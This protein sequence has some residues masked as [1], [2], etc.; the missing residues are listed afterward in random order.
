MGKKICIIFILLLAMPFTASYC[1]AEEGQKAIAGNSEKP[2]GP[3]ARPAA[4]IVTKEAAIGSVIEIKN[5]VS[6]NAVPKTID[7][8]VDIVVPVIGPAVYKETNYIPAKCD[9]DGNGIVDQ[10]DLQIVRGLQFAVKGSPRYD[11]RAD[12]NDSGNISAADLT[13]V[14]KNLGY[15][16]PQNPEGAQSDVADQAL[17]KGGVVPGY[18]DETGEWHPPVVGDIGEEIKEPVGK[19]GAVMT[20]KVTA[21]KTAVKKPENKM[22]KNVSREAMIKA[23]DEAGTTPKIL[24]KK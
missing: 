11:A 20:S 12:I 24:K 3:S 15:I 2:V 22:P 10:A 9:I 1:V 4:D 13:L 16:V 8:P 18:Y 23:L 19:S 17:A 5:D 7:G 21:A 6:R 14:R